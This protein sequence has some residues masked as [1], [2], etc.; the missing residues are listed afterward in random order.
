MSRCSEP[1]CRT[2][3]RAGADQQRCA[4]PQPFSFGRPWRGDDVGDDAAEV[5]HAEVDGGSAVELA[6]FGLCADE[7][8]RETFNLPVPA[9]ALGFVD[10]GA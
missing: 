9:F 7:A 3:I 1:S 2:T 4:S 5:W 6:E 8:D 10:P